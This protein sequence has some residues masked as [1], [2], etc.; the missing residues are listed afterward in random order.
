MTSALHPAS[1]ISCQVQ[2]SVIFRAKKKS[3][4]S[5]GADSGRPELFSYFP[6]AG[7][8]SSDQGLKEIKRPCVMFSDW[9]FQ[10]MAL[11]Q[12]ESRK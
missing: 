3:V 6:F 2:A 8:L 11:P 9:A 10:T 7:P 1:S 4:S 12:R 5:Q